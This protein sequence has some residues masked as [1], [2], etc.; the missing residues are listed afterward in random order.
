MKQF[1]EFGPLLLFFATYTIVGGEN[2]LYY[3]TGVLIVASVITLVVSKILFGKI[4]VMPLIST[5]LIVI[6]GG[7]TLLLQDKTFVKMKPTIVNLL[8]ASALMIGHALGKPFIRMLM[9]DALKM[10]DS[11]WTALTWRWAMFFVGMAILNEVLWRNFSEA[12]WVNFKVFGSMPI[13]LVF[14]LSQIPM[15]RRHGMTLPGEDEAG[16]PEEKST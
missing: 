7:L 6:F 15:M 5:G 16:E 2:G 13:T 11:G 8:F 14:A 10:N 1:L 9:G 12:F 4:P 3:A